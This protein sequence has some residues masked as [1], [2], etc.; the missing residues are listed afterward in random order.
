MAAAAVH[1]GLI[2]AGQ[3]ETLLEERTHLAEV[4]YLEELDEVEQVKAE[5]FLRQ[6]RLAAEEQF[7]AAAGG[8]NASIQAP[9]WT[10]RSGDWM[11]RRR[12]AFTTCMMEARV[13]SSVE[14]AAST[15]HIS[16]K[17]SRSCRTAHASEPSKQ[18]SGGRATGSNCNV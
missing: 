1:A 9:D 5:D 2:G 7:Q 12:G 4:A 13:T 6:A 10:L 3:V 8:T 16:R 14:V 15:G 17:S 18:R 11:T